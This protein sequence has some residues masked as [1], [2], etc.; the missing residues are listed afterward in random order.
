MSEGSYRQGDQAWQKI[1][2]FEIEKDGNFCYLCNQ[3]CNTFPEKRS[4]DWEKV[5]CKNCLQKLKKM[6]KDGNS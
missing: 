6:K 1:I 2:H 3:A 4:C 5:T